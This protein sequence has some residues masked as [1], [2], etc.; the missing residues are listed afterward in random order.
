M[1]SDD[2]VL[3]EHLVALLKG[4]QA[5]VDLDTALKGFP[6]DK[7]GDRPAG[8]PYSAWQLL[9]HMRIAVADILDFSTN[10]E[11]VDLSWPD[12]YW[13]KET[14]P[15]SDEA[16][17]K[18][19]QALHADLAEFEKLIQ[20]PASNLYATIPWGKEGQTLLREVLIAAGHTSYHLG[21]F[22]VLR[23]LLG[24]WKK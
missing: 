6:V 9:E 12:D 11:Y 3:R 4:G 16:W 19:V 8:L 7:A 2:H 1:A 17:S 22:I 15:P 23:R 24:A 5:H 14:R 20:D 10:P 18:S 21:E 13:P